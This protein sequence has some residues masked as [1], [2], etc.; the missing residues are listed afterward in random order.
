MNRTS[1]SSLACTTASRTPPD[2]NAVCHSSSS[3][4]LC[5]WIRSNRSVRQFQR[6][7]DR[8]VRLR[9]SALASLGGQK[10]LVAVSIHPRSEAKLRIA[11]AG[12][13]VDVVDPVRTDQLHGL[14]RIVLADIAN[15]S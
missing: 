6:A 9:A 11:I 14:I 1:P 13:S 12:G 3:T 15:G 4:R 5:S 8:C 7:P 2:E 10:E